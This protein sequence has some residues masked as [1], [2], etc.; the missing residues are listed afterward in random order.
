MWSNFIIMKKFKLPKRK[1]HKFAKIYAFMWKEEIKSTF[2]LISRQTVMD[3][4]SQCHCRREWN[5][6]HLWLS[7]FIDTVN[8]TANE[9]MLAHMLH[10][11]IKSKAKRTTYFYLISQEPSV[12]DERDCVYV[13]IFGTQPKIRNPQ[14][15]MPNSTNTHLFA[16]MVFFCSTAT[17]TV[18]VIEQIYI[19]LIKFWR[20]KRS[21]YFVIIASKFSW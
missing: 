6:F 4:G 17:D 16:Q 13:R 20:S 1:T 15:I 10:N 18:F 7:Y 12:L 5:L 3:S 8:C 2:F 19:D 9:Q 14:T 11:L 21:L